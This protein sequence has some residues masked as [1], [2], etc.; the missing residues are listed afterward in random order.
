MRF[1]EIFGFLWAQKGQ[2]LLWLSANLGGL[3]L[4]YA[5]GACIW[6]FRC[7]YGSIL[8]GYELFLITG[9]I[10]LT[11]SGA[12]YIKSKSEMEVGTL[13]PL[14]LI[15]WS[16]L[17]MLTFGFLILIGLKEFQRTELFIWVLCTILFVLMITWSTI[18]WVFETDLRNR[19]VP[20][21]P[22]LPE[23]LDVNNLPIMNNE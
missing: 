1:R 18:M 3:I 9:T 7:T 22:A 23:D 8:P 2:Y 20:D 15:S 13:S 12:T 6:L 17:L 11:I 4:A 16:S 19:N 21:E 14:L 10:S 5:A